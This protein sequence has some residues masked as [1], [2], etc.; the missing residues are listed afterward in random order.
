M[1]RLVAALIIESYEGTGML[2]LEAA[3]VKKEGT[4]ML[5]LVAASVMGW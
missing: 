1:L 4:A 3:S 2:R 5:R